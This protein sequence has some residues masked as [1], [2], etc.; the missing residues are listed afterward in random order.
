MSGYSKLLAFPISS[1]L[2]G[3]SLYQP[4]RFIPTSSSNNGQ[5]RGEHELWQDGAGDTSHERLAE[6][7]GRFGDVEPFVRRHLV[8]RDESSNRVTV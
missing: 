5:D 7:R 1:C 4:L 2:F 6:E 3:D 8:C